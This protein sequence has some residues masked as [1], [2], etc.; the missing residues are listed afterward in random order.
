M[1]KCAIGSR[2]WGSVILRQGEEV[3]IDEIDDDEFGEEFGDDVEEIGRGEDGMGW[4]CP[5]GNDVD[6][7]L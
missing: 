2:G 5:G 3:I 4:A 7:V 6:R 1:L